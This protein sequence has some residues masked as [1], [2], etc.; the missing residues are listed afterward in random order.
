MR[1]G[2]RAAVLVYPEH[3]AATRSFLVDELQYAASHWPR[4]RG[5]C[6][7][8]LGRIRRDAGDLQALHQGWKLVRAFYT[9]WSHSEAS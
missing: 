8:L 5:R 3:L 7:R 6:L 2:T 1:V 4:H 9:D